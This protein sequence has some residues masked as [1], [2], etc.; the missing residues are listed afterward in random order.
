MRTMPRCAALLFFAAISLTSAPARGTFHDWRIKEIYSNDDGTVQFIEFFTPSP[1]QQFLNNHTITASSDGAQP[2]SFTFTGNI[3]VPVGQTTANHHFLVATAAFAT[4]PGS[5]TPDYS[6]LPVKFFEPNATS[7]VFTF[8]HGADTATVAG[9]LIPKDGVNSITDSVLAVAPNVDT[10]NYSTG[11]NTPTNFA[12]NTGQ[13]NAAPSPAAD[14]TNNGIVNEFDLAAWRTNFGTSAGAAK[15][16]GDSDNDQ[17]VDGRDYLKWQEQTT[18][19]GSIAVIPEPTTAAL[20]AAVL[21]V[22]ARR[23]RRSA[24]WR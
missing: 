17:D 22:A 6:P 19:A 11:L 13:I 9:S 24:S 18:S 1:S 3:P 2:V 15:A 23:R 10:D 7:I 16:Q 14:F 21:I 12:G 5:V 4:T 8:A 20:A